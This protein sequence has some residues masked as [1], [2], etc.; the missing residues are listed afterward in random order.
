MNRQTRFIFHLAIQFRAA[1]AHRTAYFH[2]LPDGTVKVTG[3]RPI[4]IGQ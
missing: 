3:S 1:H 4:Q 2:K